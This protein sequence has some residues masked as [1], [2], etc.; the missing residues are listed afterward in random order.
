MD[1]PAPEPGDLH[2]DIKGPFPLSAVGKYRYAAFYIDEY[3]RYVMTEFLHDKSEIIDATKRVMAKFNS[4]VGTPVN[5][6]GVAEPRP[7]VRRLHRDHEGGLESKQ[8]EAFRAHELLH[9][10][11]SAPHDH[12]LN[13]IAESTINVVSTL[14]TAHKSSSG[15][16]IGFWPEIIRYSVDWHNSVPQSHIGSSTA[17][18]QVSPSQRFTL[19]QPKVM[20][21]ATFGARTVVL[22]PPQRQSKTTLSPRGWVGMYL[23]RSSDALGTYEVWVP[24][25]GRKVKSSSLVID[26]EF[27]PWKG[28]KAHQPL[29]SATMTSKFL[30]DHLG[31]KVDASTISVTTEHLGPD[32]I[33]ATPLPNL[34]FLNLFSGSYSREDGLSSVMSTFGWNQ[35]TNFDNDKTLGGGWAD[36]LL[37]DSRYT[38]LLLQAKAGSWDA[39]MAGYPC[40]TTT[41]A[42]CFDASAGGG[43]Y[44]PPPVRD[45]EYPDGLPKHRLSSAHYK[46]LLNANRLADR[47]IEILIA[48]RNSPRR[49]SIVLE[50]PSDRNIPGTP[51]HMADV[52]HGSLWRMS[53][54]KRLCVA[55]PDFSMSTFANCRFDAESQKYV[56][57]WYT[58]D[59]AP[60]LDKLNEAEYQCNHP[61]GTHKAV[62]GGRDPRGF[63]LSTD[64]AKYMIGFSTKLAMAFTYARTGDPSP[65][66]VKM[67]EKPITD[68]DRWRMA[69]SQGSQSPHTEVSA[70][71]PTDAD[72]GQPGVDVVA[73]PRKLI[74]P[75][76]PPHSAAAPA[77]QASQTRTIPGVGSFSLPSHP[78]PTSPPSVDLGDG[79]FSS[80]ARHPVQGRAT[81]SVRGSTRSAT[82]QSLQQQL[83]LEARRRSKRDTSLESIPEIETG[84]NAPYTSF[85]GTPGESWGG[86][87]ANDVMGTVART[88]GGEGQPWDITLMPHLGTA[89]AAV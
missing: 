34:S 38:E 80:P 43:D 1:A 66:A 24:E 87:D 18:S 2:V 10:T 56:T 65:L 61:P 89:R 28:E 31:P 20:D 16:P 74:F 45:Y 8:F 30:S 25:I 19:K 35:I 64:T 26:E 51:Q 11:T 5:D 33:N 69:I 7:A 46:E 27:F 54:F 81:R 41:V 84:G 88:R 68:A 12:D 82:V 63:W 29:L 73:T 4:L 79:L 67:R 40:K 6:S 55:I 83:E 23:G 47:M 15:A 58:K 3:S 36:D 70:N 60:I 50:N 75:S 71:D 39:I 48:A 32:H 52:S 77:S 13:P 62:A 53:Q 86:A 49:T 76:T 21:L 78:I 59:A 44:G 9:S 17:D 22:K 42:R 37:N 14:A 72:V 57:I 85:S